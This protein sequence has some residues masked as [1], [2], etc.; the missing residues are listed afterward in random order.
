MYSLPGGGQEYG[1]ETASVHGGLEKRVALEALRGEHT[2]QALTAKHQVHS[3][4]V[5]A[6]KRQAVEGLDEVFAHARGKGDSEQEETIRALHAKL[7]ELTVCPTNRDHLN[8][9]CCK[10]DT[11]TVTVL[12]EIDCKQNNF[13]LYQ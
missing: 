7:G 8:P 13:H 12:E 2:V 11:Q 5:R 6:W 9:W 1:E 4:Q 3:N 10:S